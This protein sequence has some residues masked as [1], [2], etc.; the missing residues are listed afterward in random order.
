MNNRTWLLCECYDLQTI[1]NKKKLFISVV[2]SNLC[3]S[4][5][6]L[7]I[8]NTVTT[9]FKTGICFNISWKHLWQ[10]NLNWT[11]YSQYFASIV[12]HSRGT[13]QRWDSPYM[14]DQFSF[15]ESIQCIIKPSLLKKSRQLIIL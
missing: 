15:R 2:H 8:Q 3:K 13:L 6:I 14:C 10:S 7:Q 11:C 9:S 12:Y 4:Y 1:D 5:F